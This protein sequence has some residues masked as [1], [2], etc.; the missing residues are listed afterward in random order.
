MLSLGLYL[1]LKKRFVNWKEV[2]QINKNKTSL[3]FLRTGIELVILCDHS[4]SN[5]EQQV[6]TK[7]KEIISLT[8]EQRH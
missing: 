2:E 4:K 7:V 8:F 3:C 5:S 1:G 6:V